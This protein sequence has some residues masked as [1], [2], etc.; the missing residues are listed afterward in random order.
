MR[1]QA[2][3]LGS[4]L[5]YTPSRTFLAAGDSGAV[6][7]VAQPSPQSDWEVDDAGRG[8]FT[9]KPAS[10]PG[11][12]LAA[13]GDGTLALADGGTRFKF[14]PA[15][16]CADHP[17]AELSATGTPSKGSEPYRSV[18]GFI[19]GHMHWMTFEYL[20]GNFH[21]G[22]PW[23]PYGIPYALPDCSSIEG[24]QGAGRRSRTR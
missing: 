21:C 24:P 9:L 16:G 15:N 8:A 5:L 7:A 2:T 23:S 13:G 1:I 14:A 12:A 18:G 10:A 19:D 6:G 3:R 11:K 4:Y 17:E 20:G 22:R